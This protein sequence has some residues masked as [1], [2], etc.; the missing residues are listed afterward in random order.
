[1]IGRML[2]AGGDT[3][4]RV[5]VSTSMS[6]YAVDI[7][8][9]INQWKEPYGFSPLDSFLGGIGGFSFKD[10]IDNGGTAWGPK[11]T[12]PNIE[13]NE[14]SYPILYLW[15]RELPDSGG[16]GLYRGGNASSLAVIPHKVDSITHDITAWGMAIPTSTGLFGAMPAAPNRITC[17][18]GSD[19]RARLADGRV[20]QTIEDIQGERSLIVQ[21]AETLL[22]HADDVWINWWCGGAGYGDPLD[23]VPEQ[24]AIDVTERKISAEQA[25]LI[26]GVVLDES[27]GALQVDEE[28][29][30]REREGRRAAT[31]RK[32][33]ASA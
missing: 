28:A 20:P 25:R 15:R 26:Y 24:V 14:Q 30:R 3:K 2:A 33:P 16:A 11:G 17:V 4:D 7:Y 9:G 10:G 8:S 12:G 31:R 21:R 5:V 23:R 27:D 32:A 22:Q 18:A 13:H 6:T 1:V 19:V 29:T